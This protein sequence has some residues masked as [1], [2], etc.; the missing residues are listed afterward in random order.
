[1]PRKAKDQEWVDALAATGTML[2]DDDNSDFDGDDIGIAG[3]RKAVETSPWQKG[4]IVYADLKGYDEPPQL[5]LVYAV[6]IEWSERLYSWVNHAEGF[7][8]RKDGKFGRVPRKVHRGD[9][10]RGYEK[11]RAR[12]LIA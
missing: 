2:A 1:M 3:R 4:S 10:T 5:V 9:I 6:R 7:V 8:Q 12:G 11:A